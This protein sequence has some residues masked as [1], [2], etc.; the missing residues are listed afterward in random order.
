MGPG[1]EVNYNFVRIVRGQCSILTSFSGF[2]L[3]LAT[4]LVMFS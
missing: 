1:L 2:M 3:L 4:M